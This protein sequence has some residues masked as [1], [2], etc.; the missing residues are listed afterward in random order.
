MFLAVRDAVDQL[1]AWEKELC[2]GSP[3]EARDKGGIPPDTSARLPDSWNSVFWSLCAGGFCVIHF[4]PCLFSV[5]RKECRVRIEVSLL[6][7]ARLKSR[8]ESMKLLRSFISYSPVSLDILALQSL[9][10]FFCDFA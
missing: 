3:E 4:C 1:D 8:E 9:F 6:E 10:F 5:Q 2:S 7:K